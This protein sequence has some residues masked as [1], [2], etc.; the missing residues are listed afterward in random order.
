MT[1]FCY[2]SLMPVPTDRNVAT[3]R[4]LYDKIST[5]IARFSFVRAVIFAIGAFT[6]ASALTEISSSDVE[7]IVE[8]LHKTSEITGT[9]PD[10]GYDIF[11][12]AIY[13]PSFFKKDSSAPEKP[14]SGEMEPAGT[15]NPETVAKAESAEQS[16]A[17]PASVPE[18][19][20]KP[21]V[22]AE[23]KSKAS[24]TQ[25]KLVDQLKEITNKAFTLTFKAPLLGTDIKVDLR[26]WGFL[27]FPI[28]VLAETY[29][30]VL[31]FKRKT[32]YNLAS[33]VVKQDRSNAAV[34]DQLQF[35][36]PNTSAFMRHPAQY[37]I[38]VSLIGAA[39][40]ATY[41]AYAGGKFLGT[42]GSEAQVLLINAY[43]WITIYAVAYVAYVRR[44]LN[45]P[46]LTARGLNAPVGNFLKTARAFGALV[47]SIV[48]RIPPR[49]NLGAGGLMIISTLWLLVGATMC[50]GQRTGLEYIK[51]PNGWWS[52]ESPFEN[53]IIRVLYLLGLL[54]AAISLLLILCSIFSSKVLQR[55]RLTLILGDVAVVVTLFFITHLSWG[56]ALGYFNPLFHWK[57]LQPGKFS[58]ALVAIFLAIGLWV[59]PISAWVRYR[60]RRYKHRYLNRPAKQRWLLHWY[61]PQ[62]AVAA[63]CICTGLIGGARLIGVPI[64]ILG[65]AIL[66]GTYSVIAFRETAV[67]RRFLKG[68]GKQ[69]ISV[70][71]SRGMGVEDRYQPITSGRTVLR[72]WHRPSLEP[73][74]TS[75]LRNRDAQRKSE[76]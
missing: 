74:Q 11:L 41:V 39:V 5:T 51:R 61:Y 9:E 60:H 59:L 70:Q 29:L 65:I 44:Q 36:H 47:C 23:E 35:A 40:L 3:L 8:R 64:F 52:G 67:A 42:W 56:I 75:T 53:Q 76:V 71:I 27:L 22:T 16:T 7:Q 50:E 10:F 32:I 69:Q 54:L 62:I 66:A 46:V 13:P 2:N 26:I 34:A 30:C 17:A 73:A 25:K 4:E 49:L 15:A 45:K 18:T 58:E 43:A 20:G 14:Q 33:L 19:T 6:F 55:T 21:E 28:V 12:Y 37:E 24:D 57:T 38:A 72:E 68:S 1:E 48:R 31:R 63:F